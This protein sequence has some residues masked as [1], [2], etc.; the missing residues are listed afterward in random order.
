MIDMLNITRGVSIAQSPQFRGKLDEAMEDL[1]GPIRNDLETAR[2]QGRVRPLDSALVAHLLMGA[3]EYLVYYQE[4]FK[5]DIDTL[6]TVASALLLN[7]KVPKSA[8]M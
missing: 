5:V 1:V 3:A 6:L 4:D 2:E 7:E 8:T